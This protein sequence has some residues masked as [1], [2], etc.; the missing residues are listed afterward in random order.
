MPETADTIFDMEGLRMSGYEDDDIQN[1]FDN[2]IFF[3]GYRKLRENP[4]NGNLL[5]EKPALFALALSD[6]VARWLEANVEVSHND[7]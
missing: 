6:G 3:D 1:I 5:L 7:N 2:P 4:D